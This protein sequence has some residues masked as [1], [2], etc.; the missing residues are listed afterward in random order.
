MRRSA[1]GCAALKNAS[2]R[3]PPARYARPSAVGQVQFESL[4]A[5]SGIEVDLDAARR[6]LARV[7]VAVGAV[8]DV[9]DVL[10]VLLRHLLDQVGVGEQFPPHAVGGALVPEIAAVQREPERR[11]AA[12][13]QAAHQAVAEWQRFVP[14]GDGRREGEVQLGAWQAG[15]LGPRRAAPGGREGRASRQYQD[16]ECSRHRALQGVEHRTHRGWCLPWQPDRGSRT[17]GQRAVC[18]GVCCD[19]ILGGSSNTGPHGHAVGPR[20]AALSQDVVMTAASRYPRLRAGER[21]RRK[22]VLIQH[23]AR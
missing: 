22:S 3:A 6:D 14:G 9:V 7:R 23:V 5:L 20:Q 8:E 15:R 17:R 11:L 12:P 19:R 2:A 4:D 13:Q 18:S 21:C 16:A 1:T 10:L